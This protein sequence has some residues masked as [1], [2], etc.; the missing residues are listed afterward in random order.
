MQAQILVILSFIFLMLVVIDCLR[1]SMHAHHSLIIINSHLNSL[2]QKLGILNSFL[3]SDLNLE[4]DQLGGT[5][6]VL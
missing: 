4:S 6:R 3:C 2:E 5:T 1:E